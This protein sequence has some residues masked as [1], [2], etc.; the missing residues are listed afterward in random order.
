MAYGAGIFT[1]SETAYKD[2]NRFKDVLEAEGNKQAKYLASMDQFYAQLDELTRQFDITTE[3]R[4]RFFEEEM[5]LKGE[6]LEYKYDE[7]DWRSGESALD[8]ELERWRTGQEIDYKEHALDVQSEYNQALL[9]L[10]R[11]QAKGAEGAL[12]LEAE[13]L[14]LQ[15]EQFDFMRG[16]YTDVNIR[17]QE[18][19]EKAE[20]ILG[21]GQ[22]GIQPYD[23]GTAGGPSSATGYYDPFGDASLSDWLKQGG[24]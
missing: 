8:R 5:A 23:P 1:P 20:D 6:E 3:Q 15:R 18:V 22:E 17:Q 11:E 7:L 9:S 24:G 21:G 13:R 12:D 2:P 19:H 10:Q 4:E 14:D 16:I